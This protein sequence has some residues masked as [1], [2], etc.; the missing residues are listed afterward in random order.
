[1]FGLFKRKK[2]SLEDQINTFNELGICIGSNISIDYLLENFDREEYEQNPYYTLLTVIGEELTNAKDELVIA[3]NDVWHF[4]MECV[5]DEDIYTELANKMI[6]LSKGKLPLR[7]IK[8]IVDHDN[9]E[10]WI[11]FELFKK[12][13]NWELH[14]NYDWFDIGLVKKFSDLCSELH[15]E[16]RYIFLNLG[17]DCIISFCNLDQFKKINKLMK[18]KFKFLA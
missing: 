7:N 3:S 9:E 11:S 2:I 8:S 18:F 13:Y 17:Q 14:Y 6:M 1:M 15:L 4:D 5:E 10:A 16:E 12:E